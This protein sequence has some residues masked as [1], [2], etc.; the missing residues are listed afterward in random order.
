[1]YIIKRVPNDYAL[2]NHLLAKLKYKKEFVLMSN[3]KIV[4]EDLSRKNEKVTFNQALEYER[5]YLFI[6]PNNIMLLTAKYKDQKGYLIKNYLEKI[7]TSEYV[8]VSRNELEEFFKETSNRVFLTNKKITKSINIPSSKEILINYKKDMK[9]Y[10][11]KSLYLVEKLN[12]S[13]DEYS[14]L[15]EEKNKINTII[16]L[17]QKIDQNDIYENYK[18][19]DEIIMCEYDGTN[20]NVSILEIFYINELNYKIK[21]TNVKI[22]QISEKTFER[23]KKLGLYLH[24]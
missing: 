4:Y 2:K 16:S 6:S 9:E 3:E 18:I 21:K 8:N 7:A 1:M 14:N 12:E 20:I 5:P 19:S 10:L 15:E 22:K 24:L 17:I 23:Q 11:E 13:L